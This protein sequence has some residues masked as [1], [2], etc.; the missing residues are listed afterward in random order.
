MR[1]TLRYAT[2]ALSRAP[3]AHH[4]DDDDALDLSHSPRSKLSPSSGHQPTPQKPLPPRH[5]SSSII[6]PLEV[7]HSSAGDSPLLLSL[8]INCS[9]FSFLAFL[10]SRPEIRTPLPSLCAAALSLTCSCLSALSV[11]A[12][13]RATPMGLENDAFRILLQEED[14]W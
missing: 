7:A 9:L 11:R 5:L 3:A 10:C 6:I 1:Q 2:L 4:N 13:G 14:A 8:P 12:S